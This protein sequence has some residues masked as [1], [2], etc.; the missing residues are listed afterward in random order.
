[1]C[2]CV[3]AL[4]TSAHFSLFYNEPST[5]EGKDHFFPPDFYMSLVTQGNHTGLGNL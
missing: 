5:W 4:I 1:M 2:F 3:T